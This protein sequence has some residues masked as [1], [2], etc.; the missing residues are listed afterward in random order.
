M[1]AFPIMNKKT[2]KPVLN[3]RGVPVINMAP[4]SPKTKPWKKKVRLAAQEHRPEQPMDG[5][6]VLVLRFFLERPKSVS[7]KKRPYPTVYPDNDKLIRAIGDALT[8]IIYNDD[9]QVVDIISRK[10][11]GNPGVE[12]EVFELTPETDIECGAI[13]GRL[14]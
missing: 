4:N 2:G 11:Y 8:G 13:Q 5:A 6:I 3:E 12:I 7:E 14:F 10:R 9:A 1:S